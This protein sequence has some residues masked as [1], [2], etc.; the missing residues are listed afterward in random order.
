MRAIIIFCGL[1]LWVTLTQA[2]V[3]QTQATINKNECLIGDQLKLELTLS[4]PK[5]KPISFP[6]FTD[7][8]SKSIEIVN[9]SGIDTIFKENNQIKLKQTLTITSFD[10]GAIVIPPLAFI[11]P[12]DTTADTIYTNELLLTVHALPVD[13]NKKTIFDIKPP[14]TEPFSW[15]EI[16]DYILWGLLIL[17]ILAIAVYI[18]LRIRKNKPI[19]PIPEKPKDPPYV[20]A[21]NDLNKLK[22]KKLWQKQLY[23]QYYSELTDI[24]RIYLEQQFNIPALESVSSE[25]INYL[26]QHPFDDELVR[27]MNALFTTADFVKFAKAEPLPDENDWHLKNAYLFVEKTKPTDLE[28]KEEI[29]TDEQKGGSND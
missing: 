25:L 14:L 11:A 5:D 28:T 6:I 2:Q 20:V 18:Y 3:I 21:L 13:T 15:K 4:K 10:T 29:K 16:L 24:L 1:I 12:H 27:T 19:I 7:T 17:L 22:E 9:A 8:L 26:K 23:K